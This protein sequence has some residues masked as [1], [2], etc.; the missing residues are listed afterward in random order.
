[1]GGGQ[2]NTVN[3][4]Q[5]ITNNTVTSSSISCDATATT[6]QANNTIIVLDSEVGGS[7]GD[8]S[9]VTVD[10]SCTIGNSMSSAISNSL[11]AAVQ[12]ENTALNGIMGGIGN[13]SQSNLIDIMQNVSNNTTVLMN[14][15]C[16]ATNTVDQSN[17]LVY[18]DGSTVG[19]NVGVINTGGTA[20]ASCTINNLSKL[21]IYNQ[22]QASA[23]QTNKEISLLSLIFIVILLCVVVCAII[24]LAKVFGKRKAAA[25]Q[26]SSFSTGEEQLINEYLRP[27]SGSISGPTSIAA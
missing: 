4:Q 11:S 22:V 21:Q 15:V 14:S 25:G 19:Q 26:Q 10:A 2:S 6:I 7:V 1:M 8:I 13:S 20:Y 12:Q 9:G 23:T 27:T 16:Q 24:A 18:V 3:L 17:N 5:S